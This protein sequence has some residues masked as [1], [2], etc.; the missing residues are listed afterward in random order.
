MSL[1]VEDLRERY[2]ALVA[3]DDE[4]FFRLLNE[5]DARLLETAKW[6]W[7]KT[8]ADLDVVDGCVYVDPSDYAAL[9]GIRVD[10]GARV[11][12]PRE[13]EYTPPNG[14]KSEAGEPGLGHLVDCGIVSVVLDENVGAVRRRKYRIA[15]VVTDTTVEC[16]LHLAHI[17]VT[18]LED[19]V[20]CPSAR[21][22]KLAMRAINYEEV[23]DYERAKAFW[24]DAY[25]ALNE[26]ESTNR[27][28]VRA[29]WQIQPFGDGID[30]VGAI[31]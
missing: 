13:I 11:I 7:C 23:D 18:G 2:L 22:L 30:P 26:N 9:L 4:G 31:M 17:P 5:A 1:T 28:G 20:F 10:D 27:G 16:L 8:E 14:V 12:R 25:Q 6:N 3:K 15:D 29:S 19:Y 21:A 24:A